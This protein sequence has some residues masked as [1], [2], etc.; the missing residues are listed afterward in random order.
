[1]HLH[2]CVV[3][4]L[5]ISRTL[6]HT[7]ETETQCELMVSRAGKKLNVSA[8]VYALTFRK[9]HQALTAAPGAGRRVKMRLAWATCPD[10][11]CLS[12]IAR[13][14]LKKNQGLGSACQG[15]GL[16]PMYCK[17]TDQPTINYKHKTKLS[18]NNTHDNQQANVLVVLGQGLPEQSGGGRHKTPTHIP[19]LTTDGA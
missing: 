11:S 13:S 9:R 14:C 4:C 18:T 19:V 2:V 8:L 1:M 12:F 7:L 6:Q 5:G 10:Q 17:S 16:I 3:G 15:L